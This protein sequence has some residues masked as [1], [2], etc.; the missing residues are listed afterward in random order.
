MAVTL[1]N[2]HIALLSCP[3]VLLPQIVYY[4]CFCLCLVLVTLVNYHWIIP[5]LEG[6]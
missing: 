5:T 3:Y 2:K 1:R 6:S 4:A